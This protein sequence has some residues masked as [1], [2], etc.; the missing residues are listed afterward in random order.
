M[1][2]RK[3]K[4]T[5]HVV[6]R[7]TSATLHVPPCLQCGKRPTLKIFQDETGVRYQIECSCVHTFLDPIFDFVM[8]E[9][10]AYVE[11]SK[12]IRPEGQVK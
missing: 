4:S 5:R 7:L 3:P 1:T 2:K 12:P 10:A 6:Y 11:S 9:W 8:G